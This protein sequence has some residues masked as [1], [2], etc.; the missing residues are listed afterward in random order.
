METGRSSGTDIGRKRAFLEA[1]LPCFL[2]TTD[3]HIKSF[4]RRFLPDSVL[5]HLPDSIVAQDVLPIIRDDQLCEDCFNQTIV[6]VDA[7]WHA[8]HPIAAKAVYDAIRDF[9][10]EALVTVD[11][12]QL[13]SARREF[14]RIRF[15]LTDTIYEDISRKIMHELAALGLDR[16][17]RVILRLRENKDQIFGKYY[18]LCTT[19]AFVDLS[20]VIMAGAS[21]NRDVMEYITHRAN[22]LF[23][24]NIL[25]MWMVIPRSIIWHHP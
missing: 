5:V 24:R 25:N 12:T 15:D 2:P 17:E 21:R 19:R 23:W 8:F 3:A 11:L 13:N 14:L 10:F 20:A 9:R 6:S 22:S 7:D 1:V 16:E 18:E 4:F